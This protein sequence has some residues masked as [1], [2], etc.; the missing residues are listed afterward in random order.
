[1]SLPCV[2]SADVAAD[3]APEEVL[4]ARVVVDG[5]PDDVEIGGLDDWVRTPESVVGRAVD[6]FDDSA[7]VEAEERIVVRGTGVFVRVGVG[8][9]RFVEAE[10]I[11][12]LELVD[13]AADVEVP[14]TFVVVSDDVNPE[15]EDEPVVVV[16]DKGVAEEEPPE[17]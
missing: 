1:M 15:D 5:D 14:D 6:E 11:D 4:D 3:V 17:V 12:P 8:L 16:C 7:L 2:S 13:D 10:A 9:D